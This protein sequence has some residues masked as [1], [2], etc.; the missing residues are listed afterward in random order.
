MNIP[1]YY[2]MSCDSVNKS[3]FSYASKEA[4]QGQ[5][6]DMKAAPTHFCSLA[7]LPSLTSRHTL[8][9]SLTSLPSWKTGF[10]KL[11]E[12]FKHT[13][14]QALN[15]QSSYIARSFDGFGGGGIASNLERLL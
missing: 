14:G 10:S 13:L 11:P 7:L 6:Q 2:P 5:G 9:T 12:R 1:I 3:M 15:N 8:K 4:S